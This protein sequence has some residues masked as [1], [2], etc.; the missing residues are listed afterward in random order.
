M[1]KMTKILDGLQNWKLENT[2]ESQ[3]NKQRASSGGDRCSGSG[4]L[5]SCTPSRLISS[6][7]SAK[8]YKVKYCIELHCSNC[9]KVLYG[10]LESLRRR[11]NKLLYYHYSFLLKTPTH[12]LI[13]LWFEDVGFCSCYLLSCEFYGEFGAGFKWEINKRANG[14]PDS[15][16]KENVVDNE[17]W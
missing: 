10:P 16:A 12:T 8:Q 5:F 15:T 17:C 4:S 14:K 2:C 11:R 1:T 6:S 9:E 7:S 3:H 13:V